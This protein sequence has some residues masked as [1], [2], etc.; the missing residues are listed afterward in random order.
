MKTGGAN[1]G[2][3]CDGDDDDDTT[4]RL[5]LCSLL[6]LSLLLLSIASV[7]DEEDLERE[8]RLNIPIVKAMYYLV[9]S[10]VLVFEINQTEQKRRLDD[11]QL[12]RL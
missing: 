2:N 10:I 11:D 6:L 9:F 3:C 7:G 8:E 5:L 12:L 4:T 1:D